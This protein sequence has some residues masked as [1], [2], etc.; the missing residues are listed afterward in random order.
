M[1]HPLRLRSSRAIPYPAGHSGAFH[2]RRERCYK[3]LGRSSNSSG[4]TVT[5]QASD[6]DNGRKVSVKPIGEIGFGGQ[7][8]GDTGWVIG[9]GLAAITLLFG[10]GALFTAKLLK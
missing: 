5:E 2:A 7:G 4:A 9:A 8:H 10:S 3:K 1:V 6:L